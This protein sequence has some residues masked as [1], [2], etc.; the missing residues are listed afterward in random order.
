ML[1]CICRETVCFV[2][3]VDAVSPSSAVGAPTHGHWRF[4]AG[5]VYEGPP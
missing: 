5:G 3:C 1:C 2:V 4:T